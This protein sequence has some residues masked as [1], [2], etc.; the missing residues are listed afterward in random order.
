MP[1]TK[2]CRWPLIFPALLVLMC[3]QLHAQSAEPM[4][5]IAMKDTIPEHYIKEKTY[6]ASEYIRYDVNGAYEQKKTNI[7]QMVYLVFEEGRCFERYASYIQNRV[8]KIGHFD[9][10]RIVSDTTINHPDSLVEYKGVDCA[11]YMWR[12]S[13]RYRH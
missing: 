12:P 13:Y 9:V 2:K 6:M 4:Y 7:L 5:T 3:A 10:N 1:R 11:N 8:T